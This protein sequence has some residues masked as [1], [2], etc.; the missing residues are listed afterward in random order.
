MACLELEVSECDEPNSETTLNPLQIIQKNKWNVWVTHLSDMF[1][2][3][4]V[5]RNKLSCR[6]RESISR[7]P[8]KYTWIL[9]M[10]VC[11]GVSSTV[12]WERANTLIR[13]NIIAKM[14]REWIMAIFRTWIMKL[15]E[16]ISKCLIKTSEC[17]SWRPFVS[18]RHLKTRLHYE[19]V[20]VLRGVRWNTIESWK[21]WCISRCPIVY[22]G[23][24]GI[25]LHNEN[26]SVLWGV[27]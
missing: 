12:E 22:V 1:G 8:V 21:C 18:V 25:H 9:K 7:C 17:I 26:V 6:V 5:E 23:H 10:L 16:C 2:I 24:L 20:R 19:N 14:S 13:R 27:R 15:L 11:F 4:G 3:G